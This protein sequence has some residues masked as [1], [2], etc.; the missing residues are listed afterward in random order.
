MVSVVFGA[1][2]PVMVS[3][4]STA[5]FAGRVTIGFVEAAACAASVAEAVASSCVSI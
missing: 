5:L 4:G 2:L 3:P 1:A